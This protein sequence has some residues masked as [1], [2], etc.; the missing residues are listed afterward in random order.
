MKYFDNDIARMHFESATSDEKITDDEVDSNVW[1]EIESEPDCEFLEDYG[2]V[3]RVILTSED[4]VIY[5][6][7][8]Y[9]HFIAD[10]V[11]SLMV[12]DTNRYAE[13]YFLTHKCSK[14]S[15]KLQWEPTTN[16]EMMKFFG[17]VIEM[18]LVQMPK[19]D[20]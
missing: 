13:Q 9:R 7:D 3:E 2:I 1:S 16:D 6:V 5:S 8:C 18:C 11:I 17:I 14:R 12:R 15:K 4:G 10:E 19:T 20:Y